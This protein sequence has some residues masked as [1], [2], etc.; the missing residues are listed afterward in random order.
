MPQWHRVTVFGNYRK[1]MKN[2]FKMK[3]YTIIEE[4]K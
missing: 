1:E 3:G 2:L 4:D